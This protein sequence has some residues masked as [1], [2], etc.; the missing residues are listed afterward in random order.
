MK[1][2]QSKFADIIDQ[3]EKIKSKNE[4]LKQTI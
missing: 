3:N 2:L 4:S 1:E